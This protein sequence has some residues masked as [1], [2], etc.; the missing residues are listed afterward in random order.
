MARSET[1]AK[2]LPFYHW[3]SRGLVVVAAKDSPDSLTLHSETRVIEKRGGEP[4]LDVQ[5]APLHHT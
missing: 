3:R 2:Q 1:S 5:G 4:S